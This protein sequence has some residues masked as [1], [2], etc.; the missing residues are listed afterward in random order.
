M[1]PRVW[2]LSGAIRACH[3]TS[4]S[5]DFSNS[6]PQL[7]LSP[8]GRAQGGFVA[9]WPDADLGRTC[10][11]GDNR[12]HSGDTFSPAAC[13]VCQIEVVDK[14]RRVAPTCLMG[15]AIPSRGDMSKHRVQLSFSKDAS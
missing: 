4:A 2:D 15:A 3:L 14:S 5:D 10:P 1:K 11:S 9:R 8:V 6:P 13:S 7:H 12:R